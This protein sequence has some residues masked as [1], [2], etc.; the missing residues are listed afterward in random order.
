MLG[1][2]STI[3][4][5]LEDTSAAGQCCS[6]KP[7]DYRSPYLRQDVAAGRRDPISRWVRYFHR[8]AALESLEALA[9]LAAVC[10]SL[11]AEGRREKGEGRE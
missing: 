11:V 10:G 8:R 3:T 1:T 9:T 4:A 5:Y 2:F 7:D 6:Y